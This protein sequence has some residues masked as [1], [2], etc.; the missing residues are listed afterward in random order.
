MS[1]AAASSGD[2]PAS[3]G[4]HIPEIPEGCDLLRAG[5]LYV[6]AGWYIGPLGP[7][8]PKNPGHLLGKGWQHRT[9][10]DMDQVV[11][12]LAGTNACGIF[13]HCGRSGAVAFDSDYAS[14]IPP[15]LA[16]H[17]WETLPDSENPGDH[18]VPK[19]PFQSTRTNIGGRGHFLMLQPEDVVLGNGTGRLEGK[20]GQVRGTN[21]VIVASP[22]RH[23]E[24]DGHYR[25]VTTGPLPSIPDDLKALLP[26]GPTEDVGPASDA[27]MK[28]FM[29]RHI[30]EDREALMQGPLRTFT[31]QITPKDGLPGASR[32]DTAVSMACWLMREAA[33]GYYPAR[34]AANELWVLFR[35]AM[36]GER[37]RWPKAEYQAIV[38]WAI[39]QAEAQDQ[40]A[41]RQE[42][43][44][45][46]KERDR[47]KAAEAKGRVDA[48][49]IPMSVDAGYIPVEPRGTS[50]V[51]GIDPFGADGVI[52]DP[53]KYFADKAIGMNVDL[54]GSDVLD[55]GPLATGW[56]GITWEYRG[57]VWRAARD[58]VDHRVVALMGPRYRTGHANNADHVVAARIPRIDC[59]PVE[60]YLNCV[61]GM[62]NWR[63]GRIE[64]HDPGYFSTVQ[65]PFEWDPDAECPHFEE[66]LAKVLTPDYVRLVWEMIGYLLYS[67]NPL[68]KAFMLV[69]EGSN[70]KGTL[71]RVIGSMLGLE[72]FATESLVSLAGNRFAALSLY[73]KIANLAGDIDATFQ[74][75][76]ATFKQLTGEDVVSAERKYGE[77]FQFKCWAVPI[78][79]ANKI[80]GS[81][82]TTY[83]YLRRWMLVRF[84][85]IISPDEVIPG[86]SNLLAKEIPGIAAK[87]VRH[88]RELLERRQFYSLGEVAEG[89]EHFAQAVDQVRQW[90][91]EA[92]IVS[93]GH[94][95][96]RS[97]LYASYR[98]WA[99]A[100]G[101]GSLKASEFYG[102]LSSA[103][104]EATKIRGIRRHK[105]LRVLEMG[106]KGA[107]FGSAEA[108]GDGRADDPFAD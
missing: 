4:L 41:R 77:R 59:A 73:G 31:E 55:L 105:G 8:D 81:A 97:V 80:P 47:R 10:R 101:V 28:A 19:V 33:Q 87:A 104:H 13:L 79:S 82:D 38:A 2:E 42:T 89:Q 96:D 108:V 29:D 66:F 54:L 34:L 3:S 49:T 50:A 22:S 18:G 23:P 24:D 58:V 44:D 92:C 56:D 9:S 91:D 69:G 94:A 72:N 7:G 39:G 11:E 1:P 12:W 85:R 78:F 63:T 61:N 100:N 76:T 20:W 107:S 60:E 88:L 36:E 103:G 25:W 64:T 86:Y 51:R 48:V 27:R 84:D 35:N 99:Q 65:F 102:R 106:M 45:R 70:G 52:P 21:G 15:D 14:Q 37:R 98:A 74:T 30:R 90:V 32:H 26:Q 40:D 93:P 17:L 62:V 16:K 53:D 67:G 68:E 75:E 46:L 57:G 5:L 43:E 71:M 6:S 83:G 95:E